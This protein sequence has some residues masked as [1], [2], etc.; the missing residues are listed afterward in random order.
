M[1]QRTKTKKGLGKALSRGAGGYYRVPVEP[2]LSFVPATTATPMATAMTAPTARVV[3]V[4]PLVTGRATP[5][6]GVP[7]AGAL[8]PAAAEGIWAGCG[9]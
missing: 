5:P 7:V 1:R 6:A 9:V 3:A 8:W 4:T 2:V